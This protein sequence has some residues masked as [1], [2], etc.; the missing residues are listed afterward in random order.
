MTHNCAKAFLLKTN[1]A[2][3]KFDIV[4]ISKTSV[5]SII[6]TGDGILE[7]SGYNLIRSDHPSNSKRSGVCIY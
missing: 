7:V 4:C 3:Y 6:A 1:I 2:V 5:D